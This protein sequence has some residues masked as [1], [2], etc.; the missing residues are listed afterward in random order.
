MRRAAKRDVSEPEIVT[1]LKDAGFTVERISQPGL[2]D[3]LCG[4]RR[5]TFLVE[6]KSSD[7]GYGAKLNPL[8]QKFADRWAGTPIVILRSATDAMDWAVQIAIET[9]A[10]PSKQ[11][12]QEAP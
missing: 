10:Q 6:C 9:A 5:R 7:K 4:F 11:I 12:R 8:Q 2:P 1:V 3:L